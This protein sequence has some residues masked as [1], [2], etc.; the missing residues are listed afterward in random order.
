MRWPFIRR[1]GNGA[2]AAKENADRL[3]ADADKRTPG[4][5]RTNRAATEAARRANRFAWEMERALHVRRG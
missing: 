1:R 4:V 3:Y 5:E 2:A